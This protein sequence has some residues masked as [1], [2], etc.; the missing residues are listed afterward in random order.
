MGDVL[1]FA[2]FAE[3]VPFN[4]AGQDDGWCAFVFRGC[5]VGGVNFARIVA[6]KAQAAQGVVGEGLDQLQQSWIGTE[7]MLAHVSAG[8]H[9]ELL[10]F[11]VD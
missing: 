2:G 3:T 11:A 5:F 6:A 8:F 1:A 7:E 4:S 10:V 9:D